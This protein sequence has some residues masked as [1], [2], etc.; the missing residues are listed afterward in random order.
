[1]GQRIKEAR[2]A[3]GFT[4]RR[5]SHELDV[6]EATVQAW[7]YER[8]ALSLA[9]AVQLSDL[10]GVSVGW[11]ARGEEGTHTDPLL[12]ELQAILEKYLIK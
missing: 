5:V 2:E 9:R 10:Y 7:E 1:M 12:K 4:Q 6:S 3:A 11:I 8:A